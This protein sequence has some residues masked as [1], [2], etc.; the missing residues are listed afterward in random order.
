MVMKKLLGGDGCIHYFDCGDFASI[1]YMS[2]H[3]IVHFKYVQLIVS[4]TSMKLLKKYSDIARGRK[5]FKYFFLVISKYL[6]IVGLFKSG[7][8]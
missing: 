3:R 7:S 8:K 5:Y 1:Y 2:K 6:F 4:Y